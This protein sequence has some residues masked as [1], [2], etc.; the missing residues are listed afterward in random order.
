MDTLDFL[1]IFYNR[2]KVANTDPQET[3]TFVA[4][5]H[6]KNVC[7]TVTLPT[8]SLPLNA[9]ICSCT[10]CRYT[11]GTLGS[12]H[13]SLPQGVAPEWTNSNVNLSVY[14]TPGSGRGGHGQR[15][16]CP[17]CGAHNGHYEAWAMQWIVDISLFDEVFWNITG[18]A[19]PK[20][21]GDGGL[22]SWLGTRELIP[23]SMDRDFPPEYHL[24]IGMDGEERLRAECLCGGVSFTIPRPSDA[25][26]R[27][28]HFSQHAALGN[29]RKWKAFLDFD[30]ETRLLTSAHFMPWVRIPRAVFEPK[31]PPDL[32]IGTMKAYHA[33]DKTTKGFCGRCGATIFLK[34][35]GRRD[36]ACSEN[37]VLDIALGILRA[38]EGAKAE[39][40][41]DWGAA[42]KTQAK[43]LTMYDAEF[44]GAVL[45][46]HRKWVLEKGGELLG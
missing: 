23:I 45:E 44:T 21:P 1:T 22:L 37:E 15:W 24:E 20:S 8:A 6:C 43:S 17:T 10:L 46:G 28:E 14:K 31:V 3:K 34:Q 13:T 29:S 4:R 26:V 42:E 18:F 39:N 33:S 40:W 35:K 9:Y 19:F 5:C 11:H 25:V 16:F 12:F 32:N 41:V 30:R 2:E 38:P 27:D 7:F 36:S